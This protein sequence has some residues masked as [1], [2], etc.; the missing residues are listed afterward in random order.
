MADSLYLEPLTGGYVTVDNQLINVNSTISKVNI[1]LKQPIGSNIYDLKNGNP[2]LNATGLLS[3]SQITNGL[4][5]CL[6]PLITTAEIKTF[7]IVSFSYTVLKKLKV[8][9]SIILPNGLDIPLSWIKG[10]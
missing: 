6:Q 4:L 2:L 9:L 3:A 5:F 1:L 7:T 10:Q 8:N